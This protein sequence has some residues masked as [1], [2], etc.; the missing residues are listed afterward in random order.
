MPGIGGVAGETI[1][2]S[3][4]VL[5]HLR[6]VQYLLNLRLM[7]FLHCLYMPESWAPPDV[8]S[9]DTIHNLFP[10]FVASAAIYFFFRWVVRDMNRRG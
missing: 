10:L 4:H 8:F 5:L 9:M 1:F 2:G 6:T 7:V 3:H